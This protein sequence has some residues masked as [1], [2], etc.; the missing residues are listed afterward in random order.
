MAIGHLSLR[1][2]EDE[3]NDD[4]YD[5]NDDDNVDNDDNVVYGHRPS[6]PPESVW[7]AQCGLS[8]MESGPV[9]GAKTQ[10]LLLGQKNKDKTQTRLTKLQI[11][12]SNIECKAKTN[13]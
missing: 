3:D 10:T 12:T 2:F 1:E 11:K 7:R 5:D 8:D 9:V 13:K 4:I 6:V